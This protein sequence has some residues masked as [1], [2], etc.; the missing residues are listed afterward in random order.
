MRYSKTPL[1]LDQQIQKLQGRGLIID[2]LNLATKFLSTVSYYRLRAYTYPFQYPGNDHEFLT[3]VYLEDIIDLY[4]FD[5]KLRMLVFDAIE[6]IEIAFRTQVIYQWSLTHGGHWQNEHRLFIDN[7]LYQEHIESLQY[8]IDRSN[9]TF[10]DHYIT[11]YTNPSNPPSWMSLEVA[12]IGLVSK[13]FRNLKKGPEKA[14]VTKY[15][16]LNHIPLMENWIYCFSHVRNIC[17]HHGRLWNRRISALIDFPTNPRDLFIADQNTRP[18][19]LYPHLCCISYVL[20][21]IDSSN[22]FKTDLKELISMCPLRQGK[23]LGFTPNWDEEAFW[24]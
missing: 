16:G 22:S 9:E 1:N 6:K 7:T 20:D 14:A 12:S 5:C 23:E 21:I 17:A 18:Y 2:D 15:F 8:E 19:K 24:L 3:K 10:I 13:I 11:K 4:K